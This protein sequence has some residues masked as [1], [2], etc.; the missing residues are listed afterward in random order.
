MTPEKTWYKRHRQKEGRVE[1]RRKK[2]EKQKWHPAEEEVAGWLAA[3]DTTHSPIIR[4]ATQFR[5]TILLHSSA[6]QFFH[7]VLTQSIAAQL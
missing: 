7:S 3:T 5:Y 1:K 4:S 2:Q 6:T